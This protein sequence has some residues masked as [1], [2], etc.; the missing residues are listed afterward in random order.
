VFDIP[1]PLS[2]KVWRGYLKANS[3]ASCR[4][5]PRTGATSDSALKYVG[6]FPDSTL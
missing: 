4:A 5:A 2:G 1:V 6:L 3:E